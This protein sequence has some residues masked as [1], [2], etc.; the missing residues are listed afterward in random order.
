MWAPW[1]LLP[2]GAVGHLLFAECH[3]I[4]GKTS[5]IHPS[6]IHPLR[7]VTCKNTCVVRKMDKVEPKMEP[8]RTR[9]I[10]AQKTGCVASHLRH[11]PCFFCSRLATF[12]FDQCTANALRL[13]RVCRLSAGNTNDIRSTTESLDIIILS[14]FRLCAYL[15]LSISVFRSSFPFFTQAVFVSLLSVTS[16]VCRG[17][18]DSLSFSFASFVSPYLSIL[19]SS[20]CFFLFMFSLSWM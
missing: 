13:L 16:S 6:S 19:L 11:Q 3:G 9:P 17:R 1:S 2:S 20:P 12:A 18:L 4:C 10:L 14:P 5:A 7:A 15:S 8:T